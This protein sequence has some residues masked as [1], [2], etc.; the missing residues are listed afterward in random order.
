MTA[1]GPVDRPPITRPLADST[2]RPA[3]GAAEERGKHKR[4]ESARQA[5]RPRGTA[6]EEAPVDADRHSATGGDCGGLVDDYV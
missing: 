6:R 5:R 2:R 1:I 3:T 4:E